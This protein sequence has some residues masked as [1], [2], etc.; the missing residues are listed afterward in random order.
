MKRQLDKAA[1]KQALVKFLLSIEQVKEAKAFAA[2]REKRDGA[3]KILMNI[4]DEL[5]KLSEIYITEG[6]KLTEKTCLVRVYA[7]KL[8]VFM[9]FVIET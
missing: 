1:L 2:A 6:C 7:Q 5:T 3:Y 8:Q 4:E 9:I